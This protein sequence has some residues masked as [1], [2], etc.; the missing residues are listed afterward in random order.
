MHRDYSDKA[1]NECEEWLE[2]KY[3]DKKYS[4]EIEDGWQTE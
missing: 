4:L 3:R 1:F 2:K